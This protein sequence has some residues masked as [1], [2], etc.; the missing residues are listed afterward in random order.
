MSETYRWK[1]SNNEGLIPPVDYITSDKVAAVAET[2]PGRCVTIVS[3]DGR[4]GESG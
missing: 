3:T 1:V 4:G 2:R